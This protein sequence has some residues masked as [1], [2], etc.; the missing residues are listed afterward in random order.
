MRNDKAEV[1]EERKIGLENW[2][3]NILGS[4]DCFNLEE[5]EL[6]KTSNP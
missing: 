2:P 1:G 5:F 3:G 4:L 6:S